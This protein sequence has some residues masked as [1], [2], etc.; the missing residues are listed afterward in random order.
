MFDLREYLVAN[1][2]DGSDDGLMTA[3]LKTHVALIVDVVNDWLR[4]P[5]SS[6]ITEEELEWALSGLRITPIGRS[7]SFKE[8]ANSIFYAIEFEKSKED[9]VL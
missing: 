4:E 9:S 7:W 5:G 6:Y 2:F 1:M 3:P 8:T